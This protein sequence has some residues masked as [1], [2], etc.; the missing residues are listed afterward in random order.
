MSEAVEAAVV[1]QH[2]NAPRARVYEAWMN[3]D[4]RKRWWC[5]G[6][7]MVCDVCEIDPRVGGWF[8]VNMK[9][10]EGKAYVAI[11]EFLELDP[12][13]LIKSTW[14]WESWRNSHDDS[15]LTVAFE[16]A[17]GGTTVTLTHERLP[18]ANAVREHTEGWTYCL[19][20]LAK[21]LNQ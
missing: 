16:P 14:R 8:R 7:G 4:V 12:P 17:D 10:S 18:D 9:S 2:V 19:G 15:V 13:R 21:N 3:P 6:D 1:V 20:S 11:G 5:A